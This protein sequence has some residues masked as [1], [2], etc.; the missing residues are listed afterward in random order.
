ML[1]SSFDQ[2]L[3]LAAEQE[4]DTQ[5]VDVQDEE[6]FT[7]DSEA[8]ESV[9]ATKFSEQDESSVKEQMESPEEIVFEDKDSD[10]ISSGEASSE[11][12]TPPQFTG[13]VDESGYNDSQVLYAG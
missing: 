4:T 5:L 11:L 10:L 9:D 2:G 12:K 1:V 13:I 8:S 3:L 7:D 6:I